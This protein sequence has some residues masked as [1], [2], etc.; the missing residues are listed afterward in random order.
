MLRLAGV[1][2]LGLTVGGCTS[3]KMVQRDGC[4]VRRTEKPFGRVFEEVGPCA[5]TQPQWAQDRLTRLVQECVADADSTWQARELEVWSRGLPYPTPQ[6][7]Q[8]EILK[9]CMDEARIALSSETDV[10]AL[11]SRLAELTGERDVLRADAARDRARLQ[12]SNEK[13]ADWLGK[14]AQKPPGSATASAT[15]NSTSDGKATTESGTT[16]A[17]ETGSSASP[18]TASATPAATSAGRKA[19]AHGGY[20]LKPTPSRSKPV[21]S[22]TRKSTDCSR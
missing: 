8:D 21:P 7:R 9:E 1:V 17:A 20:S 4:W 14:A 19:S 2:L 6:P 3:V 10:S 13:I 11:R 12:E 18:L 22:S 5:R 16:L 15:S